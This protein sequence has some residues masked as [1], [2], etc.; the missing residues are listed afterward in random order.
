[1]TKY[2]NMKKIFYYNII[3]L[4]LVSSISCTK[5][6]DKINTN[7]N[8]ITQVSPDQLLPSA[9]V[10]SFTYNLLRNRNFNNELMQVTVSP[11]DA[12]GTVFRYDF[13]STWSRLLMERSFC[14]AEQFQRHV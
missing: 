9:L 13:R 11:S 8:N 4:V 14:G 5:D 3:L 10:S 1:M 12:D 7:P 2:I 6:F